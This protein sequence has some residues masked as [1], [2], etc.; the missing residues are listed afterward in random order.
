MQPDVRYAIYFV[1]P[2]D[3]DLYRFGA[4]VLGYDCYTGEDVSPSTDLA[5][6]VDRPAAVRVPRQYGFH[7]TLKAPFRL[8]PGM[9]ERSLI[10]AFES[11]AR[12]TSAIASVRLVIQTVKSFVA[13]V[14]K[15]PCEALSS[16]AS[17]CV[18]EFDE[19][20]APLTSKERSRRNVGL[21][22]REAFNLDRWGYPYVFEDFR[23]H[24]T[25]TGPLAGTQ[26]DHRRSH[27]W[28]TTPR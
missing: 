2:A 10:E 27:R 26:S 12:K 25:L 4:S 24:M 11:L 3:S 17:T 21:T 16:L 23:F 28:L 14:P 15:T 7:A 20:S 18:A 19:F 22:E 9:H 6:W 8:A 1:P 5:E 13:L